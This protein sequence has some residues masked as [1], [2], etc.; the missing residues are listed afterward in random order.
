MYVEILPAG[1]YAG[2]PIAEVSD[3]YLRVLLVSREASESLRR[4]AEREITR[5][6]NAEDAADG[7]AS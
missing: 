4:A 7:G 1:K 3:H 5:R 2:Q 6:K